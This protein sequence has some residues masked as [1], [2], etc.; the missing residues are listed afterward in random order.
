MIKLYAGLAISAAV[1][2]FSWRYSYISGELEKAQERAGRA[3]SVAAQMQRNRELE[4][5]SRGE[6]IKK[7][8]EAEREKNRIENCIADRTCVATVRVR[9]PSVCPRGS[10]GDTAGAQEVAAQLTPAAARTRAALEHR[11]REQ[12]AALAMCVQTLEQWATK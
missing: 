4:D 9:V 8:E 5:W 12:E 6:Y 2:L 3:E 10:E 11:I 1:A 7:L